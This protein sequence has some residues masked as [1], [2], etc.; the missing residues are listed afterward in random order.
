MKP[1]ANRAQVLR[2]IQVL[3]VIRLPKLRLRQVVQVRKNRPVSRTHAG[4][5]RLVRNAAAPVQLLKQDPQHVQLRVVKAAVRAE[6]IAQERQVRADP[7]AA[8][9]GSRR[10]R[11]MRLPVIP[12]LW[13]KRINAVDAVRQVQVNAAEVFRKLPL[14]RFRIQAV[15]ALTRHARVYDDQV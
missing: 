6:E 5:I 13:L 4:Q 11:V 7:H 1:Q 8:A 14:F 12:A 10:V 9:K 2:R 3:T 15:N